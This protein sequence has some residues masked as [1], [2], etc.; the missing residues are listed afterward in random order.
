MGTLAAAGL[1]MG[2]MV[3][4]QAAT[5]STIV[6]QENNY[7]GSF[8]TSKKTTNVVINSTV[9]SLMGMGFWYYNDEADIVRNTEFGTYQITKRKPL[10]VKMTIKSGRVWSD[11]TP[12]TAVDLLLTHLVCSPTYS[13]AAGIGDPSK[14]GDTAFEST[15]YTG[16]YG[17]LV[18]KEPVLSG[19]QMSLTVTFDSPTPDY[20]LYLPGPA[21]VHALVHMTDGEK[22]L[23]KSAAKNRLAKAKFYRAYK[24]KDTEYLKQIAK[25]WN[26]CYDMT[27]V[28]EKSNPLAYLSNGGFMVSKIIKNNSVT[29]VRNPLY[30]S[31]PKFTGNV[32]TV[33]I[34]SIDNPTAALQALKNKEIDVYSGQATADLASQLRSMDGIRTIG[35]NA[36]AW[37]HVDLRFD[38][39]FGE[40]DTYNGVF[41]DKGSAADKAKALDLRR[42]FLLA[43]PRDEIVEKIYQPINSSTKVMNSIFYFPEQP[44]YKQVVAANGSAY[45]TEGTQADRTARALALVKKYYPNASAT[46]AGFDVKMNW[47]TPTNA[48][49]VSTIALAKAALAKAGIN[50]IAP[51]NANWNS[52]PIVSSEYDAQMFAWVKTSIQQAIG[53]DG[54]LFE[55]NYQGYNGDSVIEPLCTPLVSE[56]QDQALVVKNLTAIEKKMHDD[57]YGLSVARHANV[58]G[59]NSDLDGIRL[60]FYPQITWNFWEWNFKK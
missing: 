3:P 24:N 53:C 18:T 36:N 43:W 8:N 5:R 49:R 11:G 9:N 28:N 34:R 33:I 13:K 23:V 14:A 22:G 30:N 56:P 51:G 60:G 50:L 39:T 31:G 42:A 47:G 48:R 16:N 17:K 35:G 59:V 40:K 1:V 7:F 41:A 6:L 15:C 19:D 4:A 10:T 20:Q 29:M 37:E 52:D 12:I 45:Y 2:S 54:Y 21:A 26:N 55:N 27:E 58:V 44:Q 57:A 38:S 32:Q 25:C 46:T